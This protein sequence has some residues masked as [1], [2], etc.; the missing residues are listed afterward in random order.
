MQWEWT[1]Q[2]HRV[3][4]AFGAES[5]HFH[6]SIAPGTNEKTCQQNVKWIKWNHASASAEQKQTITKWKQMNNNK[7][8]N[9]FWI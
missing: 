3:A 6:E 9:N 2:A 8:D 1:I 7:I 4:W 5:D